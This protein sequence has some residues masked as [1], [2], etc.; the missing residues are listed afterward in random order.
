MKKWEEGDD[1]DG[2]GMEWS[3]RIGEHWGSDTSALYC[4]VYYY[5]ENIYL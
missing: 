3:K 1:G 5:K 2:Y 4:I